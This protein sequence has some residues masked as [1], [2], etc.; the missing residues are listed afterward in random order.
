MLDVGWGVG[1]KL[2]VFAQGGWRIRVA[3]SVN[4]NRSQ[5]GNQ[6]FLEWPLLLIIMIIHYPSYPSF[7]RHGQPQKR[8]FSFSTGPSSSSRPLLPLKSPPSSHNAAGSAERWSS[9]D[10]PGNAARTSPQWPGR[11][12]GPVCG[13]NKNLIRSG[14]KW[15]PHLEP[16]CSWS[17][18]T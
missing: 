4:T 17:P 11:G 10:F 15:Y 8:R 7:T 12:R 18:S 5:S 16:Q 3:T 14:T 2:S 6:Q 1:H 9:T 13:G